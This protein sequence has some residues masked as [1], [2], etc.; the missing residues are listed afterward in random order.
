MQAGKVKWSNNDI[1]YNLYISYDKD[2]SS[3]P[4][5]VEICLQLSLNERNIFASLNRNS[6]KHR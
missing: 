4:E 6:S 3:L 5:N 2:I 1:I